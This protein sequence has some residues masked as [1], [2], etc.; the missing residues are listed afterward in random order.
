MYLPPRNKFRPS[1][2][3]FQQRA[4]GKYPHQ[5]PRYL[6]PTKYTSIPQKNMP[7]PSTIQRI[8]P[9]RLQLLKVAFHPSHLLFRVPLPAHYLPNYPKR[10]AR[11]VRLRRISRK[12]FVRQVR[13][14]FQGARG[15][16]QVY[17]LPTFP[18]SELRTPN[19]RIQ[20]GGEENVLGLLPLSVI[21]VVARPN[22]VAYLQIRTRAVE[23]GLRERAR[24]LIRRWKFVEVLYHLYI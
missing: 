3:G 12:L 11:P 15:L 14:V 19:G 10:I 2:Q 20:G 4:K 21:R 1:T 24:A 23:I 13:I 18:V 22:E 8:N 17:P 7:P 16:Y 5:Q 6:L 9:P